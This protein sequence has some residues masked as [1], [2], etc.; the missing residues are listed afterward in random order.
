MDQLMQDAASKKA[1]V[2][3]MRGYPDWGGFIH[4]YIY[5]YFSEKENFYHKIYFP[6]SDNIGTWAYQKESIH[7]YPDIENKTTHRYRGPV[8]ILVNSETLSASELYTMNLQHIFPSSVTIG[9]RTAGADGNIK[10]MIL[11]G[12]YKFSFTGLGVFYPN[13]TLT[14]K[15]GVK[16]DKHTRYDD[17]EVMSG[18]DKEMEIVRQLLH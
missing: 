7:Y 1:I 9:Q 14:Q 8:F 15:V 4:T 10:T 16:I 3:D 13:G 6:N 5:K 17:H 2:F 11:P 12:G 18:V